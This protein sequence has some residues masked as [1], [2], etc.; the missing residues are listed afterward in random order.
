MTSPTARTFTAIYARTDHGCIMFIS[1]TDPGVEEARES[2]FEMPGVWVIWCEPCDTDLLR[3]LYRLP[4]K[5][6]LT[7]TIEPARAG[8]THPIATNIEV[9]TTG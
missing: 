7:I 4:I 3:K 8:S 6:P 1:D 5:T 9:A 2:R